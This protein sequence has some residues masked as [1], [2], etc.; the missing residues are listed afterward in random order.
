MLK[1]KENTNAFWVLSFPTR[2]ISSYIYMRCWKNL[3]Y[4]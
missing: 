3:N 4:R 2:T 1:P